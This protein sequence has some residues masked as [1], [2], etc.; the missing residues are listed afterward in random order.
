[1]ENCRVLIVEDEFIV[2]KDIERLLLDLGYESVNC[3]YG[4]EVLKKVAEYQPILILMDILLAGEVSG[5]E[6]ARQVYENF[7]IPV[8]FL[9]AFSNDELIHS[10]KRA[11]PYGYLVKPFDAKILKITIEMA[12]IRHQQDLKIKESEQRYRSIFENL[13]D[14]YYEVS[15]DGEILDVSPSCEK[16]F[17]YKREELIGKSLSSLYSNYAD[18]SKLIDILALQKRVYDYEILLKNR[19]GKLIVC[20]INAQ[21][22]TDKKDKPVKIAG[23]LRDITLRKKIEDALKKSEERFRQLAELLPE[24]IYEADENGMLTF[25]NEAGFKMFGYSERDFVK[26]ISVLNLMAPEYREKTEAIRK[27]N[28]QEKNHQL[29]YMGLKKDNTLF[30]ILFHSVPFYIANTFAGTRGIVVDISEQKKSQKIVEKALKE[31]ETLLKEVHHRIKNNFQ[32]ISSIFYIQS[33]NIQDEAALQALREAQNRVQYMALIHENFYKSQNLSSISAKNYF[34]ELCRQLSETYIKPGDQISIDV[35]ADK[36]EMQ[37]T[38]ATQCGLIVN[39]LVTNC[40][41]YAFK[42][43]ESGKIQVEFREESVSRYLLRVSD[44]GVGLPETFDINNLKSLGLDLVKGILDNLKGEI[45]IKTQPG[46][47]ISLVFEKESMKE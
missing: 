38:L 32:I 42:G 34:E 15:M 8:I 18:R 19:D 10:A 24:T 40:L 43:M 47:T 4:E 21:L 6:A 2:A 12:F 7:E 9:T 26:G 22:I 25:V 46:T 39:E 20:S 36:S 33:S 1:M 35:V 13:Q 28:E 23:I 30:P 41:K 5:I 3:R 14:V 11:H 37:L 27:G 17:N 44:N 31:K 45:E 29:E 16:A